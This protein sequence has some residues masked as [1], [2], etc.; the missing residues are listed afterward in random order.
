VFYPLFGIGGFL[1]QIPILREEEKD[2]S[3]E[4]D[5]REKP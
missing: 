2:H 1:G 4:E 5:T 3:K